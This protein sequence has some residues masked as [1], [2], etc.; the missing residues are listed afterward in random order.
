MLRERR[1]EL[2]LTQREVKPEHKG[3]SAYFKLCKLHPTA[4]TAIDEYKN[5]FP[6]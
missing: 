5:S 3:F 1:I 2:S 6:A 4:T